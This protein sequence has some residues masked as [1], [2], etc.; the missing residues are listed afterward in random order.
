MPVTKTAPAATKFTTT[1][2]SLVTVRL[3]CCACGEVCPCHIVGKRKRHGWWRFE[4]A[5]CAFQFN[6]R[7]K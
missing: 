3:E 5:R 4:C 6:K 7:F 1:Y 2:R